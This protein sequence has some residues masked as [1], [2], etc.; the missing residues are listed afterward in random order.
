M[1]TTAPDK[2]CKAFATRQRILEAALDLFR[3]RGMA[4]TTMRDI[5]VRAGVA[6]GAAYYYFQTKDDFLAE[7]LAGLIVELPALAKR[8]RG[9][10]LSARLNSFGKACQ[11]H[12]AKERALLLTLFNNIFDV[13]H[14]LNADAPVA[15]SVRAALEQATEFILAPVIPAIAPKL[16]AVAPQ[17]LNAFL[18]GLFLLWLRDETTGQQHTLHILEVSAPLIAETFGIAAKNNPTTRRLGDAVLSV[19]GLPTASA[20]TQRSLHLVKTGAANQDWYFDTE[21]SDTGVA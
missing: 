15:Q 2:A 17:C 10:S 20:A 12:L 1:S 4:N 14:P 9:Q 5:A 19:F 6:I 21:P 8:L 13:T 16:R 11:H 3:E 7:H 18:R